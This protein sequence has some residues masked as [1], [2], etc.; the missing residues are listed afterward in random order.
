LLVAATNR[1]SSLDPALTRA[2]RL[3]LHL[4]VDLPDAASRHEILKVHNGTRPLAPEVNLE[5]WA[6]RTEQWS[7]ADLALLSNRAAIAAIRRHRAQG[8]IDAKSLLIQP[9][10]FE[11]AFSELQQQR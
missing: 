2:G 9:I 8:E 3:E 1:K 6:T 11:Q 7:G 5:N 4:T 10:D